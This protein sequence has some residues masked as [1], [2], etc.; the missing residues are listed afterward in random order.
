MRDTSLSRAWSRRIAPATFVAVFAL[1]CIG[2]VSASSHTAGATDSTDGGTAPETTTTTTTTTSTD[3]ADGTATESTTG[4]EDGGSSDST[5]S[6]VESGGSGG[7]WPPPLLLEDVRPR[8][9]FFGGPPA[10]FHFKI[11]GKRTRDLVI[12]VV[13]KS[14]GKVVWQRTRFGI[15]PDKVY[16]QRWWGKKRSGGIASNGI[17]LF[18]VK[19]RNGSVANR[20]NADGRRNFGF[21]RHK[22]PVRGRHSYGDSIGAGRGHRGQDIFAACGTK[23]QAARGGRVQYKGYQRGGAGYY[24]VIDGRRTGKDYVYMHFRGP[25]VVR[26]GQRVKTGQKV[27]YVGQSG[28]ASGC[29]LHFELW[30]HPGWYEGG[31]YLNPTRPLRRWDSWS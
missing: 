26:Q 30:S 13:R 3:E 24:I 22:F 10:R 27:G 18:R 4:S 28:N 31:R 19:E 15:E 25:A 11:G 7:S 29:H 21:Y 12:K 5:T 14:T 20:K 16:V 2:G 6:S 23:I 1:T 17:Y 8:K 9:A